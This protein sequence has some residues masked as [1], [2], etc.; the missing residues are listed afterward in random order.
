MLRNLK[1]F[2]SLKLVDKLIR[3]NNFELALERLNYL[4]EQDY[5]P[6]ETH[7]KRGELCQ[8]L[9]MYEDAYSDYT[10]VLNHYPETKSARRNRMLLNF[11]VE[12]YYGTIIDASELLQSYTDNFDILRIEFLALVFSSH[13][14]E[15]Y[16]IC[17]KMHNNKFLSIRFILNET[18][19]YTAQ[20]E[21]A[22]ALKILGIIDLID[23]NN[24]IKTFNEANI[25][26]LAGDNDK[27]KKLM[28][29]ITLE[30]PKYFISHFKFTDMFQDRDY[31]EICF[32]LELK[33]FD[34]TNTF[35][36]PF[37]ILEG[38]KKQ[39]E[40]HIIDSKECF[41][42]AIEIDSNKPDAYVLLAQTLQLMSDYDNPQY[43]VDAE[44]N[45]KQALKLYEQDN[46]IAK[47]EDMKRQIRHLNSTLK[48]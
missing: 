30:F 16:E 14:E 13:S 29:Q 11:E 36:Y 4:V 37:L 20:N 3:E 39:M 25:Y 45:Y 2:I 38:Y 24:P 15:A 31:A 27:Y 26:R 48:I 33:I 12:N 17:K 34:T 41:E 6:K 44:D 28:S 46:L 32:L 19:L 9:L 18:A 5:C 8:K 7:L 42:K 1:H 21:F 10:Y 35:T 40:G 23:N 43:K 22:K 47:A